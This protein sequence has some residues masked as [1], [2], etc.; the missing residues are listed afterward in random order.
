LAQ[1]ANQH[2]VRMG[3]LQSATFTD[4]PSPRIDFETWMER[5]NRVYAESVNV[6]IAQIERVPGK[7]TVHRYARDNFRQI[8]VTY[9]VTID[10]LPQ[11]GAYRATLTHSGISSPAKPAN[12]KDWK[13]IA[14]ASFPEPQILEEGETLSLELFAN[15]PAAPRLVEYIRVGRPENL[16]QRKEPARDAFADNTE[17]NITEPRIKVNGSALESA[18]LAGP[19]QGATLRVEIPSHGVYVLAFRPHPELGMQQSGEVSG[20]SMKFQIDQD[21]F[22]IDCSDRIAPG[23]GAYNVYSRRISPPETSGSEARVSLTTAP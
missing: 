16:A 18:P 14:P 23:S 13:L 8:Y 20:S 9:A 7:V 21:I 11:T 17:F 1:S 4:T 19:L 15:G 3:P 12:T 6:G 5:L 2:G 10:A 22:R